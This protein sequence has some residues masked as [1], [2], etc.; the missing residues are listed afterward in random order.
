MALDLP[1]TLVIFAAALAVVAAMLVLDRRRPPLGE[2]RLF[3]VL[4]VMMA[5]ALIAILM[6]AHLITLFAGT[7]PA[8]RSGF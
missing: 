8:A 6:A 3:P 4:P 1:T 5:A 7:P 2:V